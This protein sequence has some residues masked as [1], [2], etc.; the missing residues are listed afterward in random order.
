MEGMISKGIIEVQKHS[1]AGIGRYNVSLAQWGQGLVVKL[2]EIT[3][4]QWLYWNVQ[5]HDPVSGDVASKKKEELLRRLEEQIE[6]GEE[7]LAEEDHYLLDTNLDS[8]DTLSGEEHSCWLISSQEARMEYRPRQQR[9]S[10]SVQ[11]SEEESWQY[12]LILFLL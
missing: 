2:L 7:G 1:T 6:M 8:L 3:H 5:V 4:G 12:N 10:S 11:R 9:H